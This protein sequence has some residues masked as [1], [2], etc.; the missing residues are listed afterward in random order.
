MLCAAALMCGILGGS[1]IAAQA[2]EGEPV[3]GS[4]LTHQDSAVGQAVLKTRGVYL[5]EGDCSISGAGRGRIYV[6]AS[7]T[8][9]M[10]VDYV[11]VVVYVDRYDESDGK[12]GQYYTWTAED[13]D[14]YYVS[15]S[16][17]LTVEN[18]YYYRVRA[19]HIAGPDDGVKDTANSATDGIW[20]GTTPPPDSES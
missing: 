5:M 4:Y 15:T 13:T 2:A 19:D 11:G 16:D 3:D 8:A 14:T 6:Y 7:T 12:W 9:N 10:D 20:I 18:G 1:G 17:T